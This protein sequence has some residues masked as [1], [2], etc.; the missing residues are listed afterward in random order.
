MPGMRVVIIGAGM[1]GLS[2]A[3]RLA[4]KGLHVTVLERAAQPGGKMRQLSPAGLAM[5]AG[6]TVFTMRHVFESLFD[7]AGAKLDDHVRLAPLTILARHAWA[8]GGRLDLHASVEASAEAIGDFAGAAEARRFIDFAAET[9]AIYTMLDRSFMRAPKPGMAGLARNLWQDGLR[10]PLDLM[11]MRP[12]E[13]MW[14]ALSRSF[15]DPRLRQLFGRYATYCGSSPFQSPATLMLIAHAEQKGVWSVDGGMHALAKAIAALAEA[16]GAGF[17]YNAHVSAITTNGGTV[18]G[19][20]LST[21]EVIPAG[22]VI[23]NG[24]YAALGEG[25]LGAAVTRAAPRA[26]VK[27]RSLSAIVS[28]RAT[29]TSGFPLIRHNVFFSADYPAEFR[30]IFGQGRVPAE[31]TVYVCAQDRGDSG[32]PDPDRAERLLCLI[33]APANGDTQVYD[34]REIARCED[35]AAR[36]MAACGLT[37]HPGPSEATSP[38]GFH[39]LFPATGGG[40]YGQA[41]HGWQASFRRPGART[42][43]QGLYLAGG[44]VHPGP[45][46]PMAALSGMGAADSL[47]R[48]RTSQQPSRMAVTAGGMSTP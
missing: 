22:A 24:D 18:D 17:R 3:L 31:P 34:D 23:F 30:D 4:A 13:T 21:G 14:A 47:L 25:L 36:L 10:N 2:A 27:R 32:L 39:A 33:N 16:K 37:L 6:P 7:E 15:N 9:R 19:V 48:D 44:S 26:Q 29:R 45:G 5:D 35:R 42:T 8:D 41:S 38:S 11:R 46:V 12:F 40:L 1:G 43:V 20:A 28:C